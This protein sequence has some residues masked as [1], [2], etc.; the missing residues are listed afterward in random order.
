M[1]FRNYKQP[2]LSTINI[3]LIVIGILITIASLLIGD[4]NFTIAAVIVFCT[5]IFAIFI[6][7]RWNKTIQ[8]KRTTLKEEFKDGEKIKGYVVDT[9]THAYRNGRTSSGRLYGIKVLANDK[10]YVVRWLQNNETFKLLEKKLKDIHFD[11]GIISLDKIPVEVYLKDD[12]YYVDIE[13]I[14]L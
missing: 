6:F 12:D 2:L 1:K 14:K 8:T 5:M 9:F 3:I 13:S 4:M 10:I 7:N 11:N